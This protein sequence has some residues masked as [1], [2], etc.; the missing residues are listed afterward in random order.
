MKREVQINISKKEGESKLDFDRLSEIRSAVSIPLVLHGASGVSDE[1]VVRAIELGMCKVNFATEL[2]VAYTQGVR[3]IV[4]D[5]KVY[6]RDSCTL[7]SK[8][9]IKK[10]IKKVNLS[11]DRWYKLGY[12]YFCCREIQLCGRSSAG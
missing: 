1:M 4:E 3:Q 5:E 11:I 12:N 6:D 9:C 8:K 2:R 7:V 10:S